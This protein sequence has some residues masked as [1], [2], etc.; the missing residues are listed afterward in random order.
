[1]R[2][3]RFVWL[4]LSALTVHA[5]LAGCVAPGAAPAEGEAA[6]A[7]QEAAP[8]EG[9]QITATYMQSGTYDKAAEALAPQFTD[10]TGIGV[11]LITAPWDVLNQNHIT[12][13]TTG[14]GAYDVM[15]GEFWIANVFEHM[16][17]LD[18]YVAQDPAYAEAFIPG[19]W[20]P[21]PS[22]FY[23][24]KRIGVPY[25]AD[26]YGIYYNTEIF[27]Q[28]GV[29]AEWETWDDYI[30]VL[31]QLKT[32]LDGSDV[33]PMVHYWGQIEQPAAIFLGM[34]DGY[35]V[36]SD[37]KYGLDREKAIP[38]LDKMQSL[39]AYNPPDALGLNFQTGN[40]YFLN[41]KAATMVG[42]PSFIRADAD[43]P[44]KSQ[45]VG[46]WAMA[47]FPGPGFP[48][49]S[50]WNMFISKY[51][52]NPDAAWEWIKAYAN[53]ENGTAWMN[54]Y[55][56]GSPF[57]ATYE[58]AANVEQRPYFYPQ[59]MANLNKA[60]SLPWVFPAFEAFFR[61]E[62]D[63]HQGTIDAATM[64]D[65]VQAEWDEIEPPAALVQLAETQGLKQ[66]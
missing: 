58:D 16:L 1:M 11:E 56:I 38:A 49:V 3:S 45:V 5:L 48:M 32:C 43:D 7:A 28:C 63:F 12:D 17:P 10:A 21:G 33:Y 4:L 55:G 65:R 39:L 53:P 61:N 22:N 23:D 13:L 54:E 15:S 64:L 29:T 47:N 59:Q 27:E 14:T 20:A 6:P 18:D 8:A 37:G 51:S 66:Q 30:A 62:G 41:G 19:I 40:A 50:A 35:M 2:H 36:T 26:A 46:K 57:T 24:G 44:E 52:A 34:Y 25:S 60:K 42:W 31:E 9:A